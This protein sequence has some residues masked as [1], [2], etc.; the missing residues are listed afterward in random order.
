MMTRHLVTI[1]LALSVACGAVALTGCGGGSGAGDYAN[2]PPP[3]PTQSP[4]TVKKFTDMLA[5]PNMGATMKRFACTTLGDLGDGAKTALPV[6][7][8]AAAND[9]DETVKQAAKEAIDKIKAGPA[10]AAS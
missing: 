9:A 1:C 3:P 10:P 5:D 8:E 2:T 7:E 4:E 6:L